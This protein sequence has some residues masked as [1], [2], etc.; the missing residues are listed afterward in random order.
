MAN[1]RT[2]LP[3]SGRMPDQGEPGEWHSL[4]GYANEFIDKIDAGKQDDNVVYSSDV[5][6]ADV[7]GYPSPWA[8]SKF[9]KIALSFSV[10]EEDNSSLGTIYRNLRE[11][12]MGLIATITA[13]SEHIETEVVELYHE[14][15]DEYSLARLLGDSLFNDRNAW[16]DPSYKDG[17]IPFIQLIKY[18]GEIIAATS[19]DVILFPAVSY[20][21]S[22]LKDVPWY[23]KDNKRFVKPKY[24]DL[25]RLDGKPLKY[26][27]LILSKIVKNI[28][29][30]E[31][32][33]NFIDGWV[34]EINKNKGDVV[35]DERGV[36]A[37]QLKFIGFIGQVLSCSDKVFEMRVLQGEDSFVNGYYFDKND[38][39]RFEW[40]EV[41]LA[42]YMLKDGTPVPELFFG[43]PEKTVKKKDKDLDVYTLNN[44]LIDDGNGRRF[45]PLP[46]SEKGLKR[47]CSQTV[48]KGSVEDLLKPINKEDG[49]DNMPH[50][51]LDSIE[52]NSIK[53]T[54]SVRIES[55]VKVVKFSYPISNAK[56]ATNFTKNCVL[57]PNFTSA[58]WK[59]YYLYTEYV[60]EQ[61]CG[62]I[63][64]PFY[65]YYPDERTPDGKRFVFDKN[66]DDKT[67]LL[68]GEKKKE[69]NLS[70]NIVG[71][72]DQDKDFYSEKIIYV[73]A[74][75]SGK[76]KYDIWHSNK[77]IA[78]V[79]LFMKDD[80]HKSSD[81]CG[82][83]LFKNK[84]QK[85]YLDITERK[86]QVIVGYDFGSN[87]SCIF[88]RLKDAS[89]CTPL[90]F[91][92]LRVFALGDDSG[93][94]NS[95][96]QNA[97]VDELM[98]FQNEEVNSQFK[99]W[100]ITTDR[101][102]KVVGTESNR[103][104]A[105][106]GGMNVFEP[107]ID[108][109]KIDASLGIM[110]T[111]CGELYFN[112]KWAGA[113]NDPCEAQRKT[114]IDAIWLQVQANLFD[115]KLVPILLN[116]SYPGAFINSLV[117]KLNDAYER[118]LVTRRPIA[119]LAIPKFDK[120]T[121]SESVFALMKSKSSPNKDTV[122][123]AMDIGGSTTDLLIQLEK[124]VYQS[125][126]CV[127]AGSVTS[128]FE[129]STELRRVAIEY[130][131]R[132]DSNIPMVSIEQLRTKKDLSYYYVNTIFDIVGSHA[133]E[134]WA[135][136][137]YR[138]IVKNN[139]T[140]CTCALPAFITGFLAY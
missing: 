2:L 45:F 62:M 42:D 100:M 78:G 86:N 73:P 130:Q 22:A 20:A 30:F 76:H 133:N 52:N 119:G 88:Y 83:L 13:F 58:Q 102:L 6:A 23:D 57:W 117:R 89:D 138:D 72:Q 132:N 95:Y 37:R 69:D 16:C 136:D 131:Q 125:S 54:L 26:L 48:G 122:N 109:K 108:V 116:W 43:T 84:N 8:R 19:P 137:L 67:W 60:E 29:R 35:L 40:E 91:K 121:E 53:V 135:K 126:V 59:E 87:N 25:K 85:K 10:N 96:T 9:F 97:T 107:N 7:T 71:S 64:K 39:E 27:Y 77:P 140:R 139:S 68:V 3:V 66:E 113:S 75:T 46:L 92:N 110:E 38:D 32:M 82:Y 24:E 17:K 127:A 47:W 12:W 31:T 65:Y 104:R 90:Q 18:D 5:L 61:I 28:K 93:A 33:K 34:K 14:D 55:D 128:L 74:V 4:T 120:Y 106:T 44:E 103:D 112:M 101:D 15:E 49:N 134:S 129:E 50:I 51:T 105:I 70:L 124:A 115:E 36:L 123:V 98:F 111:N 21:T 1:N 56:N 94:N 114:F 11:E 41:N 81:E 99:S 118:E 63:T 80:K 79:A